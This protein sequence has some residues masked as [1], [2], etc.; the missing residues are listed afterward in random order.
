MIEGTRDPGGSAGTGR[1]VRAPSSVLEMV[2]Q[3]LQLGDEYALLDTLLGP[4]YV[5]WNRR[6]HLGGD[7]HAIRRA[8]RDAVQG[9]VSIDRF[10]PRA[11]CRATWATKFDLRGLSEFEQAVLLK[12]REIPR[13]ADAHVW[14]DRGADRSTAGGA[15]G[16][17]GAAQ[18]PGAGLHPVP[19]RR[20]Q[21]RQLGQY[22][23]GGTR[24]EGE[25]S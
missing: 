16:W 5:A 19:S 20:A 8:V 15:R 21:R 7:A 14:L 2:L 13:G 22:A 11:R 12:A 4:L 6:G 23:L 9:S 25:R 1:R 3:R 24:A 10:G 17:H 18:E